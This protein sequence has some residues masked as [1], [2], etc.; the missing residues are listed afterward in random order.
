MHWRHFPIAGLAK[1]NM[2]NASLLSSLNE[3]T[4]VDRHDERERMEFSWEK[5]PS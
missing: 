5:A 3:P 4:V 2:Q 1:L